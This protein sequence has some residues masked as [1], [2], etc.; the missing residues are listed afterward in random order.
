MMAQQFKMHQHIFHCAVEVWEWI[1]ILILHVAM[2]PMNYGAPMHWL[3]GTLINCILY[4]TTADATVFSRDHTLCTSQKETGNR[5]TMNKLRQGWN[6]RHFA[7]DIFKSLLYRKTFMFWFKFDWNLSS[8][9]QATW[10]NTAS[11]DRAVPNKGANK[12]M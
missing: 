7:N 8:K 2:G 11:D 12:Y 9:L 6:D 4:N 5:L 1:N 3:N 10:N